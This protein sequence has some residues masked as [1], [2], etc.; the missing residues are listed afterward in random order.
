MRPVT[1]DVH[2]VLVLIVSPS[3]SLPLPLSPVQLKSPSTPSDEPVVLRVVADLAAAEEAALAERVVP[4]GERIAPRGIGEAAADVAADVKAAPVVDRR[5][6]GDRRHGRRASAPSADRPLARNKHKQA[7]PAA[8]AKPPTNARKV[9]STSRLVPKRPRYSPQILA[10]RFQSPTTEPTF[11]P[12]AR[13]ER[14]ATSSD[15][16]WSIGGGK[17]ARRHVA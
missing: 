9:I 15:K 3:E 1:V 16:A 12:V 11:C 6:I 17:M 10:P 13:A 14:A 2:S 5:R 7:V 8:S 4:S